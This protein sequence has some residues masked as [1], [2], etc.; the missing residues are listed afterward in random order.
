[1]SATERQFEVNGYC[2]AAKEWHPEAKLKLIAC[3]GWLDN[4]AS[5]DL[6]AP[7]LDQYHIVALDSPGH[8]FSDHKSPQAGYN[9]WDDLLDILAVADQLGWDKFVMMGHSRGAIMTTLMA[10]AMPERLQAVVMIDGLLPRPIAI[11]NTSRQLHQ[12]LK[13]Q[14]AI[15]RKRLSSF[16]TIDQAVTARL[17]TM[18][19][20]ATG[21]RL[22]V[23]RALKQTPQGYQWR[24]DPRLT[25]AS[26]V[27]FT[28]EHNQ[29]ILNSI[30]VPALLILAE[31]GMGVAAEYLQK[32]TIPD[33]FVVDNAPGK[34]HCHMEESVA[35]V[36]K[37]IRNFI[38]QQGV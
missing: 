4:A 6:L 9:I 17:A 1:M 2:L 21:A 27:K 8:G 23:E 36:A 7:L 38:E 3:H 28:A 22:I 26:A 16:E 29:H 11:E 35:I 33:S 10:S 13:D 12:Y 19:M 20:P 15:S 34:H 18:D 31:P 37:K 14:R 30:T 5:F 24:S 25:A 32:F